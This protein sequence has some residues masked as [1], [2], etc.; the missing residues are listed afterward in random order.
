[1]EKEILRVEYGHNS[2]QSGQHDSNHKL[3]SRS[4]IK[5]FQFLKLMNRTKVLCSYFHKICS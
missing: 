2:R 5:I 3:Y 1:M 4:T